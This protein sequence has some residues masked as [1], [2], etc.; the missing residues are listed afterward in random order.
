MAWTLKRLR[1]C[2]EADDGRRRTKAR[3]K[4]QLWRFMLKVGVGRES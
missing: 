2:A 3:K 1:D 4:R